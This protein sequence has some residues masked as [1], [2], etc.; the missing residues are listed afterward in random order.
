MEP[1]IENIQELRTKFF[2]KLEEEHG[3]SKSNY[4]HSQDMARIM[5]SDDWLQR[6]LV[7][8]DNDMKDALNMLWETCQWRKDNKVNDITEQDL[9]MDYLED[10][11][12]FVHNRDKDGK[13]L[14]IFKCKK[15]VKGQKDFDE[16][17]RCVL[18]W[19]ERVERTEKCAMIT[20]FFDMQDTG[21]SNMDL[22][23]TKYLIGLCKSYYPNFLNYILIFEMPWVLNATFK[24]IRAW[25]P[26]KGVQKIRFLDKKSLK[27]YVDPDQALISWGGNDDYEFKFVP[28]MIDSYNWRLDD[29]KKKVHFADG[30]P[31]V[32][33]APSDFGD[34]KTENN[35]LNSSHIRVI[36]P[37]YVIFNSG[38]ASEMSGTIRLI[39]ISTSILTYKIKTTS[40]EKFRVRPT[41]GVLKVNGS[42]TINVVV[43]PGF[44]SSSIIRDKFLIMSFLIDVQSPT[45]SELSEMWKSVDV[46]KISQHRLKCSLA[47][48]STQNGVAYNMPS[49]SNAFESDTDQ[50][51]SQLITAINHITQFNENIKSEVLYISSLEKIIIILII[52]LG[53]AIYVI[54]TKLPVLDSLQYSVGHCVGDSTTTNEAYKLD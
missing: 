13:L 45:Q 17:K 10:G 3:H 35:L 30:S 22:E 18:Y 19:F 47:S 29:N 28:E 14:F 43:Q 1:T 7:H 50:K 16:L 40:P 9:N 31:L 48:H 38:H 39:N 49:Q 21:L 41:L 44:T 25:L 2:H 27:E 46:K 37:E 5:N 54:Y 32:E 24:V 23:Y 26:A 6:F 4:F 51:I 34:S 12:M 8:H 20:I 33:G 53:I 52:L 11:S 15:H 36:H 42:T